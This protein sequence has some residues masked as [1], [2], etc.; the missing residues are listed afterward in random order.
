[1]FDDRSMSIVHLVAAVELIGRWNGSDPHGGSTVVEVPV[2]VDVIMF[3][4]WM[5]YRRFYPF[6]P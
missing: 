3:P 6:V 2:L 4:S 5:L 1:M